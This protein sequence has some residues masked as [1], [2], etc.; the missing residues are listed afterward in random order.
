MFD[1]GPSFLWVIVNLLVLYFILKIILFKPVT[2]FMENRSISI[3]KDLE[4]ASKSKAEAEQLRQERMQKLLSLEDE[5]EQILREAHLKAQ[6]EYEEIINAAYERA[7][8]LMAK[9]EENIAAQREE[10]YKNLRNEIVSLALSSASK[11]IEANMDNK[12]NRAL[13]DKFI[14]EEGAA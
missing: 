7:E 4:N 11:V 3:E 13:V 8:S 1:F 12:A 5:T 14:K 6:K 9:A 2:E 10:M